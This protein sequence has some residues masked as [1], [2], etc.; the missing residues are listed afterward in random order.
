[1]YCELPADYMNIEEDPL[2]HSE[3]YETLMHVTRILSI[4]K[5]NYHVKHFAIKISVLTG[6]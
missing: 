2:P 4:F 6:L 1:M 5:I 3:V